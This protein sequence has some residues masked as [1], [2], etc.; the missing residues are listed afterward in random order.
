MNSSLVTRYSLLKTIHKAILRELAATFLIT[1]AFLNSVLMM[2]KLIRLSRVLSGVGATLLDM[3][4][5]IAYL[6]PQLLTLT[7]PMAFLLSTLLVYGRMNQDSEVVVMRAAGMDFLKISSPVFILGACCFLTGIAVSFYLGPKSSSK[8]RDTIATI[9]TTRSSLALEEGTFNSSFKDIVITVKGKKS[10]HTL[11]DIFIYDNRQ[12]DQA[13][14]LMAKEGKFVPQEGS[15][16][17]LVLLDG[18]INIMGGKTTTELFFER[19]NMVLS[20]DASESST[21][22]KMEYTPSELLS[23]AKDA[24]AHKVKTSLLL[25]LYR[26]FSLPAVCI[27]LAFLGPPLSLIA[28]KSGK[29]GGL[30]LGL[31]VFTVYYVLLIYG[32]NLVIAGKLPHYFGA[33]LSTILLGIFSAAMFRKASLQ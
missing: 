3:A 12:K 24:T 18:Y 21:P 9:I 17:M 32:E 29:L 11:E 33:W 14:V 31:C 28:G 26:R 13:K 23:R 2:E 1:L 25:E 15:K 19:Y 8:V 7:I 5:I 20:L 27:L 16:I 6:Q 22:R 10:P 30:A 4:K